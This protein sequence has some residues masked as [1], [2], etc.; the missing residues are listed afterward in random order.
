MNLQEQKVFT[1]FLT[2]SFKLQ[3]WLQYDQK[4]LECPSWMI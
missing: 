3:E 1:N 4:Y 2:Y